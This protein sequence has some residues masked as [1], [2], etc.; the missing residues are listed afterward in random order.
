[1]DQKRRLFIYDRKEVGILIL[2]GVGV[3][4]FAFTLGVHLGKQVVP[5]K[6]ESAVESGATEPVAAAS[7][8]PPVRGEIAQEV[9]NVPA[10]MDETLDQSLRDE[11][12]KTGLQL[13]SGRQV[14]LPT[15]V[16]SAGIR[17]AEPAPA[18]SPRSVDARPK[19]A[20]QS[21][22]QPSTPRVKGKYTLQVGSFP[23]L[24]DAEPELL[25]LN[26]NG[27]R[28]EVREVEIAGKGKWFRLFVGQFDSVKDADQAGKTFRNERRISDFV[29]VR[30]PADLGTVTE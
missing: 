8:Q 26:E 19:T 21:S 23:N 17:K 2:L 25:K 10:A 13:D 29:V 11:I 6:L 24:R 3:A 9:K 12:A 30:S 16:R 15:E 22:A 7:E 14:D 4:L 27:L 1:V 18:V 20:A 28:A 5:Q